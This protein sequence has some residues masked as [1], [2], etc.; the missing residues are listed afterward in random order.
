MNYEIQ[1]YK[2]RDGLW[3]ARVRTGGHGEEKTM[4]VSRV[5]AGFSSLV[6]CLY[7][8]GTCIEEI[9]EIFAQE[10]EGK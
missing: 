3:R 9:E 6:Q 1:T 2:D 10:S 8:V 4:Y 5:D 7:G